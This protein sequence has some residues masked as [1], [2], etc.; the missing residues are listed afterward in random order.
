MS[1]CS[2]QDD[3]EVDKHSSSSFGHSGGSDFKKMNELRGK[4]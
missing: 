4:A 1:L 3:D 2:F